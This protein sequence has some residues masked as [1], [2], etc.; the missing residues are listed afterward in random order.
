MIV[1][2]AADTGMTLQPAIE[3]GIHRDTKLAF[4]TQSPTPYYTPILNALASRVRLHVIYLDRGRSTGKRHALWSDFDDSWGQPPEFEHSFRPSLQFRLGKADFHTQVSA[5]SS[6]ALRRIA[7]DVLMVHSW[8]P[9]VVEPLLWARVT[10]RP[11]VMWVESTLDSGLLRGRLATR[12]RREIVGLA[13]SYVSNGRAA[14]DFTVGLG[15]PQ[16]EISTSCLSSPLA[17][18][19]ARIPLL[20]KSAGSSTRFLFV[21]RLVDLKRPLELAMAFLSVPDLAASTLTMVGDGPLRE[22]LGNIPSAGGRIQLLGRLEG[23]SLARAYLNADVLVVPSYREVWGLVVNEALAAGQFVVASDRVGSS[24][25]LL[26]ADSGVVVDA[27]DQAALA[28]AMVAATKVEHSL[29]ARRGRRDRVIACTAERFADDMIVAA[30]RA[31]RKRRRRT[32]G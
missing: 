12:I 16:S 18:R 15:V 2:G 3:T 20:E 31:M 7:P 26:D 32:T 28:S 8:G 25:D 4:V 5:G 11:S 6:L 29:T 22:A 14:T 23:D 13:D 30:S 17:E 1:A 24:E 19:L 21:G 27:G 10:N 9:H